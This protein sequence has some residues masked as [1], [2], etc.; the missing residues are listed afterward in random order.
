[1]LL[2]SANPVRHVNVHWLVLHVGVALV[3]LGQTLS[4]EPQFEASAVRLT[5]QPF[6]RDPSQLDHP[7]VQ[8]MPHALF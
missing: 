7:V 8:E 2:Q 4:Q 5:S 6:W 3:R 1:M